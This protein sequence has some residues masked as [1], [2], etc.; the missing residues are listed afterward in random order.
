MAVR[1]SEMAR[2]LGH[3]VEDGLSLG[4][5]KGA[6][7]GVLVVLASL[8]GRVFFSDLSRVRQGRQS[9]WHREYCVGFKRNSLL[10]SLGS[11][12]GDNPKR[13]REGN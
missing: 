6:E 2:A 4:R 12:L 1:G 8:V 13:E 7:S 9:N 3:I 10:L 5:G 11:S